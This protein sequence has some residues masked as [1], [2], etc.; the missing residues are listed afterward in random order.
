MKEEGLEEDFKSSDVS[1]SGG[2]ASRTSCEIVHDHSK[3]LLL[4]KQN[5]V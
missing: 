3:N 4:G 1:N 5:M 2:E